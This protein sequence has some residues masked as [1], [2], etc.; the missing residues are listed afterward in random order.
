MIY[1]APELIARLCRLQDLPVYRWSTDQVDPK[2]RFDYWREIRAK[3]LFGV[4]AELEQEH[5]Q[6]FFG[7]FS[8]RK[9]DGAGLIELRA[10]PYRVERST[11]DIADAPG[12][13]LCIYQQLGG[14]GW[15]GVN[16][17]GDFT[18][19]N[20][21]F[22]TSHSDLPYYTA[23]LAADGFH[24]RILK[25]PMADLPP[26]KTGIGDLVPKPF[27]G[28]PS[29]APLL[30]SCFSDL[31]EAGDESDLA[32]TTALVQALAQLALVDRGLVKP[33]GRAALAAIRVGHLSLARR[34]I[35][36]HLSHPGLSPAFVADLLGISLRHLH[37]LFEATG[38]SFSQAVTAQRMNESRRLLAEAPERPV[39]QIA[40]ACGFE[41]LATF[42]R[43]FQ[44]AHGMAPGAFKARR[45]AGESGPGDILYLK[46]K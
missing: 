36:R 2:D 11:T 37:G 17:S 26:L 23:P 13:S 38:T 7:E 31:T 10:S 8:L 20:G 39:S 12:G 9:F 16:G 22:A 19:E 6:N 34:L 40:L 3:G 33:A 25:V 15:F 46:A 4:T 30:Q 28:H 24:L 44:A 1:A 45:R 29:L 42:Y 43:A 32:A 35:T 5:R 21:R 27:T 18:I 14:G 41:S